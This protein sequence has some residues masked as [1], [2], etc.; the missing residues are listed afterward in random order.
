MQRINHDK[1]RRRLLAGAITALFA[2]ASLSAQ[3]GV[4]SQVLAA[5]MKM[6]DA[7]YHMYMVDSAQTDPRLNGGKPTVSEA[8]S[9]GGVTYLFVDGKWMKSPITAADMKKSQQDADAAN[10]P[11]C[12]HVRDESVNGEPASVW[13]SHSVTE[14]GT[15]DTDMWISKSRS[16]LLKSDIHMDVG[17]N[18]GKSHI[19]SRYEYTNVRAPAGVH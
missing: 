19:T 15:S 3:S 18:M 2:A 12:T 5:S 4:C 7:P 9:T 14:A 11:A 6:Y 13:H 16:L 17:G 8:I 1:R 10:K